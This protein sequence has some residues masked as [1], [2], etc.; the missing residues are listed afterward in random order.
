MLKYYKNRSLK[1]GELNIVLNV[2][3]N[4]WA[5]APHPQ[6][7]NLAGLSSDLFNFLEHAGKLVLL[8]AVPADCRPESSKRL[9]TKQRASMGCSETLALV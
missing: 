3:I 1:R 4:R 9:S 6:T 5:K 2:G 7:M 8:L